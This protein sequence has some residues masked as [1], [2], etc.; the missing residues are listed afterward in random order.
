M[1]ASSVAEPDARFDHRY[2][3]VQAASE[4]F[5]GR[6][7]EL[8]ALRASLPVTRMAH[9]TEASASSDTYTTARGRQPADSRNQS[10]TTRTGSRPATRSP[11]S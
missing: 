1:K 2:M 5:V 9:S 8:Q 10:R 11:A 3:S 6:A 7:A 4:M